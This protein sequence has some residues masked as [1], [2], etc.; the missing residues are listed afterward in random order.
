MLYIMRHGKTEWNKI[1]KLQGSVDIPLNEEGVL[2][3]QKAPDKYKEIE[4]VPV[5]YPPTEEILDKIDALESEIQSELAALRK[6][7]IS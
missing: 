2:V 7:L 5:E 4:Y 3:A 1:E 6:L